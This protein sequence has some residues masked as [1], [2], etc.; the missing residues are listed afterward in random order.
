MSYKIEQNKEEL[1]RIDGICLTD[2]LFNALM[3]LKI[4]DE[5]QAKFN[6]KISRI[7]VNIRK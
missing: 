3:G 5:M 6:K 2:K 1:R 4:I 7:Q